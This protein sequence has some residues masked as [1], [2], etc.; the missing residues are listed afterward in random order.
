LAI[1]PGTPQVLYAGTFG[2]GVFDFQISGT[3]LPAI[4]AAVES[5]EAGPV[6]G[7][8]VI[9]GWAFASQG[10]VQ[11]VGVDLFIDGVYSGNIPCCSERADVQAAFPQFPADNTLHSGWGTT[12]NWGL[13]SAGMHTVQVRIFN[14]SDE[15][16]FP[17]MRTVTVVKPGDFE[18]LDQFSLSG[19][20][21]RIQGEDLVVEGVVVRDKA[22]QQQR[23]I[24]TRFRWFTSSQ[25]LQTVEAVT[26]ATAFSLPSLLATSFA[27]LPAWFTRRLAAASAQAAPG[28]VQFFES[29]EESQV[30]SGVAIM[31]G[32]AFADALDASLS[33]VRLVIDGVPSSTIPCCSQRGDV[34]AAYP[35]NPSAVNSGWG[36]TVNYGLLSS[37][38]HSI[39]A[40]IA[41]SAGTS[42]SISHGV[43]VVRT[44]GF[45]FLDQFNLSGAT[46]QIVQTHPWSGPDSEE[47]RLEGVQVRD[48]ASQQTRIVTVRLRWFQNTQALGIVASAG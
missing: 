5:P 21:A 8:A 1:T 14:T 36:I 22:T 48:K 33:E 42:V 25:S 37:G 13:L 44:G 24:T 38:F 46:A 11:I 31:R 30:V 32:W 40:Q 23:A 6:S 17:E 41:D 20:A 9:R 47:I 12:F 34:A 10:S 15:Q 16:F 28:I 7:I 39:S 43:T 19:A 45:E 3:Q 27:S 29:P 35:G 4:M 18:F 26:T 2:F